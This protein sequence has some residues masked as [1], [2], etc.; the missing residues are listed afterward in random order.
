M[1]YPDWMTFEDIEEFE[2]DM[3]RYELDPSMP[4]D[5]INRELRLIYLE[6]LTEQAQLLQFY[7]S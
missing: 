5:Q 1:I 3:A 4:Y 6:Q 7:N 2:L